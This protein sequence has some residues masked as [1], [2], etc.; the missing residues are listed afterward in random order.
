MAKFSVIGSCISR[1][2]FPV[3][4]PDYTF[5]T[6]IRFTSPYTLVS[7]PVPQQY[8]ITHDDLSEG[9]GEYGGNWYRKNLWNDINKTVFEALHER[10][11]DY[12][13]VDLADVRIPIA[14]IRFP[15]EDKDYFVSNSL[16]FMAQYEASLKNNKLSDAEIT[17]ISPRDI[18]I[19]EWTAALEAYAKKIGEIFDYEKVILIKNICVS[20]YISASGTIERFTNYE[21]L[22]LIYTSGMLLDTL[23]EKFEA[24]MPGCNVIDIPVFALADEKNERGTHPLHMTKSYYSYLLESINAITAG[25]ASELDEIYARYLSIFKSE[26]QLAE[27]KAYHKSEDS[28]D[29]ASFVTSSRGRYNVSGEDELLRLHTAALVYNYFS[30]ITSFSRN[31]HYGIN[32]TVMKN[33][34]TEKTETKYKTVWIH[35]SAMK[36]GFHVVGALTLGK[37]CPISQLEGVLSANT[38]GSTY[39]YVGKDHPERIK[40]F[41]RGVKNS[42]EVV[43][44]KGDYESDPCYMFT[45]DEKILENDS[46]T[47]CA[48]LIDSG[49]TVS[50]SIER[51]YR[52]TEQLDGEDADKMRLNLFE[53]VMNFNDYYIKEFGITV[54]DCI[55]LYVLADIH[56]KADIEVKSMHHYCVNNHMASVCT[57][58]FTKQTIESSWMSPLDFTDGTM[59]IDLSDKYPTELPSESDLLIKMFNSTGREKYVIL[60]EALIRTAI[61]SKDK[62][63]KYFVTQEIKVKSKESEKTVLVGFFSKNRR[64]LGKIRKTSGAADFADAKLSISYAARDLVADTEDLGEAASTYIEAKNRLIGYLES[65]TNQPEITGGLELINKRTLKLFDTI[66]GNANVDTLRERKAMF[67][68]MKKPASK[69]M[70]YTQNGSSFL[71]KKLDALCRKHGI[72]YWMYN[73]S[74]LGACRHGTFIPWDDDIDVGIMRS[75][76]KKL[77]EIVKDD[78]YFSIDVLYNLEE[79]DRIYKFRFKGVDLPNYVD[80]FPFDYCEDERGDTWERLKVFHKHM[81]DDFKKHSRRLGCHYKST[82]TVA[83]EHLKIF[84]DLFD[85]YQKKAEAELGITDKPSKNIIYGFDT[86]YIV[87]WPQVYPVDSVFPLSEVTF[88]GT[89]FLAFGNAEEILVKNYKKPYTLPKDMVSHRH[90]ARVYE[91]QMEKL[92]ELMK[93]LKDYDF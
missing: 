41:A 66:Y 88:D 12:L 21:H 67:R 68:Q 19:T 63:A 35:P 1:D 16:P 85:K 24:M 93:K 82:F 29:Y 36:D 43:I 48:K 14:K 49:E 83:P 2:L 7:E 89:D 55:K 61:S 9:A 39:L 11:G 50:V 47:L 3:N 18:P 5:H 32:N 59:L 20:D 45:T 46:Y 30:G 13:V 15:G 90:T 28:Y 75:D 57:A 86:C 10:H 87:W 64:W 78:P 77:E 91:Y 51:A 92:D 62:F 33:F 69:S 60:N 26:K 40:K 23:Y 80:I 27:L 52:E 73:G 65:L 22:D 42:Y 17:V 58:R 31:T 79:A 81:V 53:G 72:N 8:R 70:Q 25:K 56:N 74:L 84:N 34:M 71:L 4:S 76:I 6:D 38:A 44:T 54:H 37:G